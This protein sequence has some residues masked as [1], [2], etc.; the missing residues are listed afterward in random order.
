M[1]WVRRQL[2]FGFACGI[3]YSLFQVLLF[4]GFW[5]IALFTMCHGK[6]VLGP[7]LLD[8]VMKGRSRLTA[9]GVPHILS[10]S[11]SFE[12]GQ[13]Q[14]GCVFGRLAVSDYNPTRMDSQCAP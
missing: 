12:P 13:G 11:N 3:V 7:T 2:T 14:G 5:P 1:E 10:R 6:Q 4:A 8:I 9:G